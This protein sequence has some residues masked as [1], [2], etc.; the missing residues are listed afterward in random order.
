MRQTAAI[1]IVLLSLLAV[2]GL[3]AQPT[4]I[5]DRAPIGAQV[6]VTGA[7]LD[8]AGVTVTFAAAGGGR[9]PAPVRMRAAALLEIVVP[10]GAVSGE[11][12]LLA[13]NTTIESFAFTVTPQPPLVKSATLVV[14]SQSHDILKEPAGPFVAL[15]SGITYVA[16]RGH[17]QIRAVLPSGAVQLSAGTGKAGFVDGPAA[18]AQFRDPRAVA[19]D[20]ARNRLYIADSGNHVIRLLT[21]DGVVST[22]A[23]SGRGEDRDGSGRD[24]GFKEP[25][26]LTIDQDGNLYVADTGNDKIR[27]VTPA[28]VVTTVAGAGRTGLANGPA[29]QALFK[30]PQ[31][32]AIGT[33]G[34]LYVADSGNHVLRRIAD[35]LVTTFAGTGHPGSVDGPAVNAEFKDP[36][37][38]TLNDAGEILLADSGNHQ[39]RRIAA[40]VVSTVA[41]NG[42]PG[43]IDG[44]VLTNVQYK[45]PSG[46]AVEGAIF[47]ADTN[48]DAIRILYPSVVLT[49]LYP[50]TGDPNGGEAL[51]IFGAGFVPGQTR[52]LFGSTDIAVTYVSSTQ[53]VVVTPPGTIG[54]RDITVIT[55]GGSA[56]LDGGF[57]FAAPF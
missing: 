35:G 15:P 23:G 37:G 18:T 34:V 41:G 6:M 57:E 49:D 33:D 30:K 25:S 4:F 21:L 56:R 11:A 52:V 9:L 22:F 38:L 7:G 26:G 48:N 17:H 1:G 40:G 28:G 50:R 14:A 3:A 51:R 44:T 45:Q 13:G 43:L 2:P 39:V 32:I 42:K 55:P 54:T 5:P 19:L 27:R 36:A 12:R 29:L 46:I 53:L 24:A 20:R 16:D 8:A 31:G 47:I 10:I